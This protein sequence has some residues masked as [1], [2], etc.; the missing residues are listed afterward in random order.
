MKTA[1]LTGCMIVAICGLSAELH[2]ADDVD[3]ETTATNAEAK[4]T[5]P[6]ADPAVAPLAPR[7]EDETPPSGKKT[8]RRRIIGGVSDFGTV[9]TNRVLNF[10]EKPAKSYPTP[11]GGEAAIVN[12]AKRKIVI[13]GKAMIKLTGRK[14]ALSIIENRMQAVTTP[15]GI[16]NVVQYDRKIIEVEKVVDLGEPAIM[17]SAIKPGVSPLLFT[18]KKN[19]LYMIEVIVA[20]DT[21][22]L[23]VHLQNLYPEASIQTTKIGDSVLLRGTVRLMEHV[24]Q[25]VEIAEQFYPLVL[26]QLRV[27]DGRSS[28]ASSPPKPTP[29][30]LPNP[31]PRGALVAGPVPQ[32]AAIGFA[33][34]PNLRLPQLKQQIGFDVRLLEI[35]WA[36]LRAAQIDLEDT[37]RA[38]AIAGKDGK[39]HPPHP[40]DRTAHVTRATFDRSV[41]VRLV[42]LL[43]ASGAVRLIAVQTIVSKSGR[44]V[45]L[46][47]T[48]DLPIAIN[49]IDWVTEVDP[50]S[51]KGEIRK[52]PVLR[53]LGTVLRVIP[54]VLKQ[55]QVQ[56]EI[57][58]ELSQRVTETEQDAKRRDLLRNLIG[59]RSRVF[60][61]TVRL[62]NGQCL[63]LTHA[64]PRHGEDSSTGKGLMIVV[65]PT[66]LG[67]ADSSRLKDPQ[68]PAAIGLQ[69]PR[70]VTP[71]KLETQYKE[72]NDIRG[73]VRE[74]RGEIRELKKDVRRL[75]K[76]LETRTSK[77]A[78]EKPQQPHVSKTV[79]K[80]QKQR[81][82]LVFH[83]PW[84]APS[85]K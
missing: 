53:K 83:A 21:R 70:F 19:Q 47:N 51:P 55:G 39:P 22:Q 67:T 13:A 75:I 32:R 50:Q 80:R 34:P 85:R 56:L 7:K 37:L 36:K 14:T 45:N 73:A 46:A 42:T 43:K 84:S 4:P 40:K 64:A 3:P 12:A 65:F 49:T 8:T 66:I 57:F 29:S 15:E 63:V 44:L 10:K 25:I 81:E 52:R 18:D 33:A 62:E 16:G 20:E 6:K 61:T 48:A 78:G 59:I 2:S 68:P 71:S 41:A 79:D 24:T 82:F 35:D 77:A 30:I 28:A 58:A 26:N 5:K 27:T 76:L 74:L 23:Q 11:T 1:L 38:F 69:Q 9:E 31:R 54:T 60:Q 72:P 17:I